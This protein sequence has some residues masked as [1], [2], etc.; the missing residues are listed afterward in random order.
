MVETLLA[1]IAA[2]IV[3]IISFSGYLGLLG[4]MALESAGMPL[5]SEIIMPFAGYLVSIG[6]FN[7]FLVATVGA[8]GC[9]VGSTAA[10]YLAAWGGRKALERWGRYVLIEPDE[11]RR[12][13]AFFQRY[14]AAAV[15]F[16]RL[17]PFVRT[18]IAF[19]AGLAKMPQAKFQIYT[20]LG[21]WP[22]CFALAYVG[23]VLGTQWN[24]NPT[25]KRIFHQFD[26]VI[27]LILI[28]GFAWFV[29]TRLRARSSA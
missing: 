23:E 16:G 2:L 17:L 13:E 29:W 14:G 6:R 25:L 24:T 1:S 28:L 15:F 3:N 27:L 21:S 18:Y 4:L 12:V 8:L 19:P 9:N 10:Y 20:F 26:V 7:L 5:P 22:W 11:V